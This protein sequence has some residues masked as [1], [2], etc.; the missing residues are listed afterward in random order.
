MP[1]RYLGFLKT[2]AAQASTRV[3]SVFANVRRGFSRRSRWMRRVA[4]VAVTFLGVELALNLALNVGASQA[5]LARLISVEPRSLRVDYRR[6]WSLWPAQVHVRNVRVRA[7]DA[8]LQ[9]QVEVD[10][11]RV[12]IDLKALFRRE[13]HATK[14]RAQ[15][16]GFRLRQKLD[17]RTAT[18]SRVAPLPPIPGFEG[19]PLRDAGPPAPDPTDAQYDLWSVRIENMDG[20]ARQIWVDE[21]HFEGDVHVT[22]AFFVRP[23]RQVWMGPANATFLSGSV[24][25][26]KEKLLDGIS[27]SVDCTVPPS[28]PR[29]PAGMEAFQL[30]SGTVRADADIPSPRAL[31]YY[32]RRRGSSI[33]F[34]GGKGVFHLD[35]AL[36]SGV[37]HPLNLSVDISEVKVQREGWLALGPLHFSAKTAAVGPSEWLARIAPVELRHA[38]EKSAILRGSELRMSAS[39]DEIDLAK[40][41]PDIE[42]Y[43]DL[44]AAR[45]P[46]L[47][48]V[49]TLL[50]S[51][52]SRLHVDGGSA[53]MD[54]HLEANS[55][56][57]RAKGH[58]AVRGQGVTAH[59]GRLHFG[60]R[61][62]LQAHVAS[63][64]LDSGSVDVSSALIDAR[65]VTLRDSNAVVSHW[66]GRM[67]TLDA[68]LRPGQR[69]LVDVTW[70]AKLQN[71]APVLAF[72]KRTPSLPGWIDRVVAGGEVEASG[73]LQAG[74]A[75]V[76][77]SNLKART[78]LL[79]VEGDFRQRGKAKAGVFRVSA[80]PLAVGIEL[81][82]DET[83]V[84]LIGK[85][86]EPPL[87]ASQ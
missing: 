73:R 32:T 86:V 31:N 62:S 3:R 51:S 87:V 54:A 68:K 29:P 84:I 56:T 15:G 42:L 35:G 22:G 46:D 71:A 1:P 30:I 75:F 25:V 8:N 21:F 39:V 48:V 23:K 9:W 11:V 85:A 19:P 40:A 37:A 14:L 43:G 81:E 33:V 67:E 60:G 7:S 38:S 44:L 79:S 50:L 27:G 83:N 17:V 53:S 64:L 10:E 13:F 65:D 4:I 24:V 5:F 34:D 72:S 55:R 82:N 12:S 36:R 59:E 74:K 66:W 63:L 2:T 47:R 28:D 57:N 20:R 69:V 80:G 78:G 26:G 52:P 70:T 61:V 6:A 49:N 45:V 58:L 77:L 41:A 76:T 16:I 18:E